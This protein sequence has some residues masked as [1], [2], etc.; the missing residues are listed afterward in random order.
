M[1]AHGPHAQIQTLSRISELYSSGSICNVVNRAL[2]ARRVERLARKPFCI[3][4]LIG[5]L[6]KEEPVYKNVDD[7]LRQWYHKTLNIG[8]PPSTADGA[9]KGGDKK[10]GKGKKGKGK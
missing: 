1:H 8:L 3:D 10:G 9:K 6:S 5:P 7:E 4:Q 2:T